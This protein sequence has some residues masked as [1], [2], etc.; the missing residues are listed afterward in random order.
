MNKTTLWKKGLAVGLTCLLM[1]LSIPITVSNEGYI[2]NNYSS[3]FS[4]LSLKAERTDMFYYDNGHIGQIWLPN[5]INQLTIYGDEMELKINGKMQEVENPVYIMLRRFFGLGPS[6]HNSKYK[7]NISVNFFGLCGETIVIPF[8]VLIEYIYEQHIFNVDDIQKFEQ[9]AWGLTSANFN[10]DQYFDF[11]VSSATVPFSCSTISIFYNDGNIGFTQ[12]DLFTFNYSYISDLDSGDYDNDG[13]IDL[14]FTYSEY[15]WDQGLP[16][17]VNG[18]VNL[19]FNDG[20]NNFGNCT[21]VAWHGPGIPYHHENRINPQ[22]TSA[23]Y[24]MDGDIDFLVGDNS[25]KVEFY[26]NNGFGNFTSDGVIHDFGFC[27]WGLTS[28]DYDYDGDIDVLIASGVAPVYYDGHVYLKKNMMVESN[29]STCFEPGMGEILLNISSLTGSGSLQVL[30]YDL[31]GDLDIIITLM[32]MFFLYLHEQDGFNHYYLG[33]L[34]LNEEGYADD[35]SLGGMTAADYNN[36]GKKDIILGG[37]QGMVRLCMNN[38]GQLSPLRPWIKEPPGVRPGKEAEFKFVTKD[39]NGDDISYYVDWG[40]GTNS[41]WI[42][43]YTSGDEVA[44]NHSW[45]KARTYLIK[46][47]DDDGE[48]ELKEYVLIIFRGRPGSS[49]KLIYP[50]T[51]YNRFQLCAPI[52]QDSSSNL[53]FVIDNIFINTMGKKL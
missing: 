14:M 44:L 31:D 30:D 40:D 50:F 22:L 46:A 41:G 52:I 38:Y 15:V 32:D 7:Q 4:I 5:H 53:E 26:K 37:V 18:T 49:L 8:D 51:D 28:D 11:A 17:N 45:P 34:P 48:S 2:E 6:V 19:L 39:I 23:D 36:D 24:D 20:E 21:M 47:K 42:G 27:S 33:R 43:P 13:D 1:L 3:D 29:Y 16:V 12:D 25:G 35:L 10:N 9:T